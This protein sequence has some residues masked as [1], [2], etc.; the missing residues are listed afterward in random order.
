MNYTNSKPLLLITINL[1]IALLTSC[2]SS[3]IPT[4][5]ISDLEDNECQVEASQL[6]KSI[7]KIQLETTDSCLLSNPSVVYFGDDGI[8]VWDNNIVYRFDK[9]GHFLNK[10]GKIG[11]GYGEFVASV[12]ANYNNKRGIILFG[13][14]SNEV[15]KYS[16]D[17]TYLGKFAVSGD[18]NVLMTSKWSESLGEYVCEIRHYR[19]DGLDVS[20]STWD[21]NGKKLGT[22]PVYSDD[23]VAE[24]NFT[25]TGSL[26]DTDG[27]MLFRLPFCETVYKLTK[28]GVEE[29]LAFDLGSHS[30]TREM[31]EDC[32]KADLYE[33]E[34]YNIFN[35]SV[36]PEHIYLCVACN[37]GTRDV[38]INRDD[39][40]IIHNQFYGVDESNCHIKIDNSG[41]TFW[42]WIAKGNKVADF[43]E[44]RDKT[45]NPILVIATE[46]ATN[47]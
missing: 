41:N 16:V 3:N 24:N 28:N 8:L 44:S 37:R 42:P 1:I 21:I 43:I 26:C 22:Y 23:E 31:V 29:T 35:W 14:N 45:K 38:L 4:V 6:Y 30:A 46:K 32:A 12:S 27:G 2:S 11:H 36:T 17:G 39:N 40:S 15:Y 20:L 13:T 9:S 33:K 10:I 19:N 47:K 7:D 25:H 18:D 34:C 5:D